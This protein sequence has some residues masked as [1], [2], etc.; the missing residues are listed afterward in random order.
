MPELPDMRLTDF[1]ALDELPAP[2]PDTRAMIDVLAG[3][4]GELERAVGSPVDALDA[5][6]ETMSLSQRSYSALQAGELLAA[7]H[8]LQELAVKTLLAL[9]DLRKR[10]GQ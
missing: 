2:S 8:H 7:R 5:V 9:V 3:L 1:D 6:L 4:H 10:E